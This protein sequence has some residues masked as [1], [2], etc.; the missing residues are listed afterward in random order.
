MKLILFSFLIG[1]SLAGRL[2]PSYLPPRLG[3]GFRGISG[4]FGGVPPS[5]F[6]GAG[7]ASRPF[8]GLPQP[9]FVG[10]RGGVGSAFGGRYYDGGY[11][12]GGPQIPILRYENNP[13]RGDGSYN[14]FYET[15]NGI[16]AEER[17]FLKPL[18]PEGT[19]QADGGFSYTA[20]DGQRISLQYTADE[21][22]FRPVGA[23]LP[24]PPPIPEAILR[25]LEQNRLEEGRGGYDD[26]QYR[27]ELG[28]Q[29]G[30]RY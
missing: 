18:G 19:Q 20:P 28:Y 25:S 4:P 9:G 14:W 26:G 16:V 10:G 22:G 27:S 21:N 1:S 6:I 11:Y 24:T 3:G 29:G 5:G 30:Y 23:H 17:G 12:R 8:G 13:N 2:D 7:S 15:G